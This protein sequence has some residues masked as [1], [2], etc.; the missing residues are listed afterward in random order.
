VFKMNAFKDA[1][2]VVTIDV[3]QKFYVDVQMELHLLLVLLTHAK[4]LHAQLIH[5][6]LAFLT[7]ATVLLISMMKTATK[8]AVI[9]VKIK[10]KISKYSQ[11]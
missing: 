4:F 10:K 6:Q 2:L 11:D 9:L 1:L 5:K 8:S 3:D 7:I